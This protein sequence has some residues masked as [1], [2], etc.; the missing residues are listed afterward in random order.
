METSYKEQLTAFEPAAS[1]AQVEAEVERIAALA[2]RNENAAVWQMCLGAIDLTSLGSTDSDRSITEF[3]GRAA[4]F[5][6]DYPHLP[7]PASVCVYPS[8]VDV[9]GLALGGSRIAITSV[10]GG[11]PSSQTFIEVKMLE[12]AMAVES[13][14]DEIDVVISIGEMLDGDLDR[15]AGTLALLR[16]ELGEQTVLKVIVESGALQTPQRIRDASLLAMLSGADFVKTSTGKIEPAAT[17]AAA[18]VMCTAIRDFA[19]KTGR[20]VGFKAAGGVRT[21]QDASLYYTIVEEVLGSEWLDPAL[22]RIGASG[23][24]NNL[25]SAI[26]GGEIRYF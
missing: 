24:A 22:F 10:A 17:P 11:F 18:V 15:M 1:E 13:G 9:A 23:L 26:E 3:A 14:A 5:A 25:L 16:E 20:R 19:A 21:A 7:S 4:R 8:F 12:A 6:I 2:P